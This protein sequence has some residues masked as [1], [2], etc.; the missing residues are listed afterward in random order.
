MLI[1]GDAV[2][3]GWDM[4]NSVAMLEGEPGVWT[5]TALLGLPTKASS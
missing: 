5:A 1:L 4:S 2:K 3:S